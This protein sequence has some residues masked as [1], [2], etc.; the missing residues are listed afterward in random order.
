M[1]DIYEEN[2]FI[3]IIMAIEFHN[4][5]ILNKSWLCKASPKLKLALLQK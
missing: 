3:S 5:F 4:Q 1:G 2:T